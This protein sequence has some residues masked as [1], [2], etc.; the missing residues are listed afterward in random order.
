MSGGHDIYWSLIYRQDGKGK[1]IRVSGNT[2]TPSRKKTT[3]FIN[4]E[5]PIW[6]F[7]NDSKS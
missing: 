1:P 5:N 2:V 3:L 4:D 6:F 7:Q